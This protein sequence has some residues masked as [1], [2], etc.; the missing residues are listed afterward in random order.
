M[1]AE[2]AEHRVGTKARPRQTF[3]DWL[4]RLVGD[5]DVL[6]TSAASVLHAI[7]LHDLQ[8]RRNQ[9][10]L[11]A[12]FHADLLPQLATAGTSAIRFG[13]FMPND[14]T[15]QM[16]GQ[17]AAAAARLA[18]TLA[19]S[20]VDQVVFRLALL[21]LLRDLLEFL[22]REQQQLIGIDAFLAR[23]ADA[24]QEQ[25]DLMLQRSDLTLFLL[26]RLRELLGNGFV[27]GL[28]LLEL[29]VGLLELRLRVR[30]LALHFG[31]QLLK[32][33]VFV[34]QIPCVHTSLM[35]IAAQEF[36]PSGKIPKKNALATGCHQR[37]RR[38]VG[39][40]LQLASEYRLRRYTLL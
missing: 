7:V 34:S 37:V 20:I 25:F 17:L 15:R 29:V 36:P 10:Q 38:V 35:R 6:F 30:Q 18:A 23:T 26:Q 27:L 3:L 22:Q 5:R 19:R 9:L 16:S 12:A 11:L 33:F 1:I 32:P 2:L 8:T 40:L 4:R 14:F 24:L 28:G 39:L 31:Q 21:Q 13:E